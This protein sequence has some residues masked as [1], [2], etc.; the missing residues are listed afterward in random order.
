MPTRNKI[1]GVLEVC[2]GIAGASMIL[3]GVLLLVSVLGSSHQLLQLV[4]ALVLLTV[5][6]FLT[7]LRQLRRTR[8]VIGALFLVFVVLCFMAALFLPNLHSLG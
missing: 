3:G 7:F 4:S 2:G 6:L 5:G 1:I 8:V